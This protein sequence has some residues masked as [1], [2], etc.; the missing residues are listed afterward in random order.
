MRTGVPK[1]DRVL[2]A[3]FAGDAGK[4]RALLELT[5]SPCVVNPQGIHNPPACPQGVASGTMLPVFRALAGEA[6]WDVDGLLPGWLGRRHE[7]YAIYRD[8]PE[9]VDGWIPT[10]EYAI[11][12]SDLDLSPM[13][14]GE[15]RVSSGKVTGII[16]GGSLGVERFV[17]G[18]SSDRFVL[19]PR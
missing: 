9:A 12:L 18:V 1:L 7:V 16:F 13:F 19:P 8:P 5:P 14:A 17:E 6:V 11:V 3:L 10:A 4:L 2:D 15:V